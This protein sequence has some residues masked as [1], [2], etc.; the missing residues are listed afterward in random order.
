MEQ[1]FTLRQMTEKYRAALRDLYAAFIDVEKAYDR[2]PQKALWEAWSSKGV[3]DHYIRI[4]KEM[5]RA[6]ETRVKNRAGNTL[7]PTLAVSE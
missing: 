6:A 7:F 4:I 2:V 3:T 5:H 1:I